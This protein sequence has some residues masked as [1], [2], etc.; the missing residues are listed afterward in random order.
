MC[1]VVS[2]VGTFVLYYS[3][4]YMLADPNK[5]RFFMYLN[6][7]VFFMYLFLAAENLVI[8]FFGWEGIGLCSFL[9]ITFWDTR[10]SAVKSAMKAVF[11]NKIGDLAYIL[12][13]CGLLYGI[14]TLASPLL[15]VSQTIVNLTSQVVCAWNISLGGAVVFGVG[16]ALVGKSAQ[17][18]LHIWLPDAMEGPTPVSALLHAATM[19][20]A[21]VFLL[22]KTSSLLEFSTGAIV[23]MLLGGITAV[24]ASVLGF[25]QE[26]LKKSIAY[27]TCSQLGYM[28]LICA[29]SEYGLA[30][31]H[32][33]NHAFFKALL[34]LVAGCIIH[35]SREDQDIRTLGGFGYRI[36]FFFVVFVIAGSSLTALPY[37]SGFFSKELIINFGLLYK[38]LTGVGCFTL[39]VLG[40]VF[41]ALY[42]FLNIFDVFLGPAHYRGI[43]G[44]FH[45][46]TRRMLTL[47]LLLAG[48][49]VWSGVLFSEVF[50]GVGTSNLLNLVSVGCF[51]LEDIETLSYIHKCWPL[52]INLSLVAYIGVAQDS[53][54]LFLA[55]GFY[56][57]L[58]INLVYFKLVSSGH[59]RALEASTQ[60]LE[61][62]FVELLGPENSFNT[63]YTTAAIN[64]KHLSGTLYSYL[65]YSFAVFAC[66]CLLLGY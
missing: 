66:L 41:T 65:A 8:M 57:Y 27:S 17:I 39:A 20:T 9:L 30:F 19:V 15:F 2:T 50:L 7:F 1:L 60:A 56:R 62:S 47:M 49:S 33:F 63:L 38:S 32:M 37:L 24:Y 40:A 29:L 23:L 36:P 21:G 64:Q 59:W 10:I 48:L 53:R 55:Q 5:L 35:I 42:T 22:L 43:L 52:V 4:E 45:K 54:V 31:F 11:I 51:S 12:A 28:V 14:G 34:F 46:G 13:F 18:G 58:D 44:F 26:D 16:V 61:R 25:C 6:F 3:E